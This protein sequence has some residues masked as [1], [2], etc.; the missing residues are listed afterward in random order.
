MS[1]PRIGVSATPFPGETPGLDAQVEAFRRAEAS[2]FRSAWIPNIFGFDA[3]TVV[4]LAGGVTSRI[5]LGTAVVPTYS[6]HPLYM[7][8]QAAT[9]N[10]ACGGRLALGLGPSHKVV[11]ENMLGLSFEKPARHVREYLSVLRPLLDAGKVEFQGETY[12][13]NGSLDVPGARPFPILIGGLGPVMRR[14]AGSLADGTITWMT[15]PRTIGEVLA[16][17]LREAAESAGRPAPRIVCGLP[18]ALSDDP[19]AARD[20]A[21][22]MLSIYGQLPSYRAMLDQEG[23][24]GPADVALAGGEAEL[25]KALAGLADAGVTDFNAVVIP[26]GDDPGASARRTWD[27]L[28]ALARRAA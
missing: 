8:Q 15:G 23:A 14:L 2:G 7:A 22:R 9:A 24:E 19:A 25:E 3:L 1:L 17:S 12:R 27:F 4:T 13:V 11:I 26:H 20:V 10:V 28:A 18:I 6:R 16:P 21:G 5:E